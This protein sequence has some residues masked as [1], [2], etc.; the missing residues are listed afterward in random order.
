MPQDSGFGVFGALGV[1]ALPDMGVLGLGVSGS[2]PK[3]EAL[4]P[5]SCPRT[6]K[7]KPET[8]ALIFYLNA[9]T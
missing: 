9:K 3:P 4:N 1:Q 5:E 8:E 2:G 7:P 6:L